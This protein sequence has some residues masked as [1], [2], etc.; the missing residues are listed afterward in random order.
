MHASIFE[1][2]RLLRVVKHTGTCVSFHLIHFDSWISQK[3]EP[4]SVSVQLWCV[5]PVCVHAFITGQNFSWAKQPLENSCVNCVRRGGSYGFGF[6]FSPYFSVVAASLLPEKV[7][8][9]IFKRCLSVKLCNWSHIHICLT[10]CS[11][12]LQPARGRWRNIERQQFCTAERNQIFNIVTD[13]CM[14][15]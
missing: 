12:L 4:R 10:W 7:V 9:S 8:A 6:F 2:K 5:V 15:K 1:F 14:V 13:I 3:M 11:L